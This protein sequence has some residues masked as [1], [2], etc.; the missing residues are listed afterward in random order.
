MREEPVHSTHEDDESS[1]D[2]DDE[3]KVIITV[4]Q[5]TMKDT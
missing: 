3:V 4:P 1:E 2:G 5:P